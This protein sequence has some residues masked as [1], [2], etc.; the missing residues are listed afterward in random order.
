[1]FLNLG[2]IL[3]LL[4]FMYWNPSYTLWIQSS[5]ERKE[6]LTAL[7]C[8]L[9]GDPAVTDP[10]TTIKLRARSSVAL[11]AAEKE[12]KHLSA[13]LLHRGSARA[14]T[15]IVSESSLGN[16]DILINSSDAV[17]YYYLGNPKIIREGVEYPTLLTLGS[18]VQ[19]YPSSEISNVGHSGLM[20][21]R[22]F[23]IRFTSDSGNSWLRA[24]K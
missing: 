3:R 15:F 19:K 7:C 11:T 1:M 20:Q 14:E 17:L 24:W 2:Y 4:S 16:Y 9:N 10:A 6:S 23:R 22:N 21:S 13:W 18:E 8:L 5:Q 12:R